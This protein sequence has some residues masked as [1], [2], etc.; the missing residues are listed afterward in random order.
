MAKKQNKKVVAETV[1]P[2]VADRS[3]SA[4]A[5]VS[6]ML[7]RAG[8]PV[9]E[10]DDG[11]SFLPKAS[12]AVVVVSGQLTDQAKPD[13][14]LISSIVRLRRHTEV[15]KHAVYR[16]A[17]SFVDIGVELAKV[18]DDAGLLKSCGYADVYDYSQKVFGFG[19]TSTK[20]F[21]AVASK[22]A[23]GGR[24]KDGYEGF[25]FTQLVELLP[26]SEDISSYKPTMTVSEIRDRKVL[27]AVKK[28]VDSL[29]V[30]VS[31]ALL[32][33]FSSVFDSV[34][35]DYEWPEDD[36]DDDDTGDSQSDGVVDRVGYQVK[37]YYFGQKVSGSVDF[38]S[39]SKFHV[40]DFKLGGHVIYLYSVFSNA[41]E[42]VAY[43][44]KELDEQIDSSAR[45]KA[46]KAASK[47]EEASKPSKYAAWLKL[48]D[49]D[50]RKRVMPS[51]D[52]VGKYDDS[53]F[54]LGAYYVPYDVGVCEV[55]ASWGES[56]CF[57]VAHVVPD[58]K[59]KKKLAMASFLYCFLDAKG[60]LE[61]YE[62]VSG[63]DFGGASV[64]MGDVI[65]RLDAIA[66][67]FEFKKKLAG[68]G[69]TDA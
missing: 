47:K 25:N 1:D 4:A 12:G 42:A 54:F 20:N 68:E 32:K 65:D 44:Q 26:V 62:I 22:F 63:E 60:R 17:D 9:P 49:A 19:R 18:R 38:G 15:I 30:F 33:A 55:N 8:V 35:V 46:E 31:G 5:Y 24:L 3:H 41:K 67:E 52:Y 69:K 29:K 6:S 59:D 50:K 57:V 48:S 27:E 37:A 66:K 13:V 23:E 14:S 51:F 45:A 36:G 34:S 11:D 64:L 10:D 53:P 56:L 40:G 16:V 2:S 39:D 61:T 7:S 43:V 28:D 58:P 21:I